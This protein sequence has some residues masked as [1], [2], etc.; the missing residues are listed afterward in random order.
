MFCRHISKQFKPRA[1]IVFYDAIVV[2]AKA[3]KNTFTIFHTHAYSKVEFLMHFKVE[4][5]KCFQN[6]KAKGEKI[7]EKLALIVAYTFEH[8]LTM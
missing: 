6:G 5:E 1:L 4:I 3:N 8:Q 7:I 2:I